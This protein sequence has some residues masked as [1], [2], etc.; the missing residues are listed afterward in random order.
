MVRKYL[1]GIFPF[2]FIFFIHNLNT[3]T[4]A[5]S[6]ALSWWNGY[7]VLSYLVFFPLLYDRARQML[8]GSVDIGKKIKKTMNADQ[9]AMKMGSNYGY[10]GHMGFARIGDADAKEGWLL[11]WGMSLIMRLF[12]I[13]AGPF[14]W[15]FLWGKRWCQT[16]KH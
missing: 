7:L 2:A 8:N 11:R 5:W 12:L 9:E 1:L 3:Q 15:A 16:R 4:G 6:I 13:L 14:V 10:T